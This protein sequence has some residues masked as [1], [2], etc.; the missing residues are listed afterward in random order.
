MCVPTCKASVFVA[1][2][3]CECVPTC[4]ASVFLC[5]LTTGLCNSS[6]REQI[7]VAYTMSVFIQVSSD[8]AQDLVPRPTQSNVYVTPW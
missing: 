5:T 3:V 6:A 8:I 2:C 7:A 4:K 1:V